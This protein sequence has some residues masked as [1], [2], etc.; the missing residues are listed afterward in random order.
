MPNESINPTPNNVGAK[1]QIIGGAG[2]LV[3][4]SH[5]S[6]QIAR[7]MGIS[8]RHHYLPQ[9]FL[10]G[11]TGDD[12]KL[13]VYDLRKNELREKRVTPKQIFFEWNRNTFCVQGKETD[14]VEKLYQRIDNDFAQTYKKILEQKGRSEIKAKELMNLILFIGYTY[15]RI[16]K[17]DQEIRK[18]LRHSSAQELHIRIRNKMTN[19]NAPQDIIDRIINEPAFIETYRM[20]KPIFDYLKNDTT[21]KL[22]NW[23]V[24]YSP[25]EANELHVIGDN[26]IV[27][28]DNNV[29]NIFSNELVFPL[30]K[31]KGVFHSKGKKLRTIQPETKVNIDLLLFLQSERYICGPNESYIRALSKIAGY[32]T[33]DNQVNQLKE[34]VFGICEIK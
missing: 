32:F 13:A 5:A 25:R 2:Y 33:N 31:G 18:I 12:G 15:W 3:V 14:F 22:E 16:P 20:V 34:E 1:R 6:R 10:K 9:F 21:K 7:F 8:K 26:P 28:K 11:F 17:T 4:S 27:L 24:Y 23:N 29:T 19:E 30:T